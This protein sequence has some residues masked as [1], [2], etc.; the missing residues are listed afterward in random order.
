MTAPRS[1]DSY[2]YPCDNDIA[3]LLDSPFV[4]SALRKIANL[5]YSKQIHEA[6][7]TGVVVNKISFP[8]LYKV[9]ENC[10]RKIVIPDDVTI[11]LTSRLKGTN[12]L[13]V[14]NDGKGVVFLSKTA[15]LQLDETELSF[16]IGHE[17]GH[18][19]QGNL[20]CHT[21]KGLIDNLKDSSV[22]LGAMLS[23]MIEV[24]L[25]KW[26]QCSEYTAD[27]AGLLCCE[28]LSCAESLLSKIVTRE[29]RFAPS[30]LELY[31]DH[32]LIEKRIRE[33]KSFSFP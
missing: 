13:A 30:L 17:L 1:I 32:P 15:V 25:N 9:V 31:D 10:A 19:A 20:A 18:V 28:S 29:H 7:N 23:E 33:L 24:P 16:M 27:R 6:I 22:I 14:E 3:R 26:Y 12:A 4:Q 21:I 5:Y 11:V 2:A 8:A